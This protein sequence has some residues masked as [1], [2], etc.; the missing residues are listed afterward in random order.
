MK[1]N[2]EEMR[3]LSDFLSKMIVDKNLLLKQAK[4]EDIS[5]AIYAIIAED[6]KL[7]E[8][9][10]EEVKD[11]MERYDSEL[12]SGKLD[13]NKLFNMIKQ[14]LIKERKLII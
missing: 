11:I 13:Y 2:S 4:R 8:R 9:L 1:L 3:G 7:E 6:M 5:L 14:Q 10:N 12:K